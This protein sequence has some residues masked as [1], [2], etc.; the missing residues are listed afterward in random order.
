VLPTVV[1][2]APTP[3]GLP[4]A[5]PIDVAGLGPDVAERTDEHRRHLV[6]RDRDEKFRLCIYALER[7]QSLSVVI[8]LDGDFP[9]RAAA[10]SRLW[11]RMQGHASSE[12]PCSLTKQRRDRLVLMLR[13]LDGHLAAASYQEI[14]EALFG[15][16]RLEREPWKTS[17][18]RDRTIRLVKGG[19][20]LMRDG[21]RKLLRSA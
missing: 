5:P 18:L 15:E 9:V 6:V 11:A 13:A 8:P 17:S 16:T 1:L 7:N 19:L 10:A 12:T 20:A 2:L 4:I 21:Y 3:A 14:A